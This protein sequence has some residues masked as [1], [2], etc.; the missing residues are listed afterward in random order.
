MNFEKGDLAWIPSDNTLTQLNNNET[1]SKWI[2]TTKPAHVIILDSR[3]GSYY[4]VLFEGERWL[5]RKIDLYE[6]GPVKKD[7]NVS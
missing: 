5:A 3:I 2:K 7:K 4:L 1:I 6:L